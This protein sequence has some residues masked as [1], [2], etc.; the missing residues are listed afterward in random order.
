MRT[1]TSNTSP[2][3]L[4]LAG[5]S[6]NRLSAISTELY[7]YARPKQFCRFGGEQSLLRQTIERARLVADDERIVV[8]TTRTHRREAVEELSA[9]PAVQWC[10][11]PADRGTLPGIL[12]PLAEILPQAEHDPVFV[13][14]SDHWVDDDEAFMDTFCRAADELMRFSEDV[15]LIGA[16]PHGPLDGY[17]WIVDVPDDL[18]CRRVAAF[19][20]KPGRGEIGAL[21]QRGALINTFGMVG[22]GR[23]L[24]SMMRRARPA[25][26]ARLGSATDAA[27]IETTYAELDKGDF[28][29]EVLEAQPERL[30]VMSLDG[31][32]WSDVGTPE[33]LELARGSRV[34]AS[35]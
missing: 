8:V 26:S 16:R 18:D 10:E 1:T 23:V 5:G 13:M 20:E 21:L 22:T 32:R 31:V 24:A 14:P 12:L 3:V 2:W 33:R 27:Q 7:G 34:A 6:G 9:V 29:K 30:R 11:Q 35:V 17:G 25:W 4:I 28:S 15:V 19:V